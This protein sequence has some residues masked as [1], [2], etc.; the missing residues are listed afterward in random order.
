MDGKLIKMFKEHIG[1]GIWRCLFDPSS[2]L[3]VT[4]GFDSAIKVHH[5]CNSIFHDKGE[6]KLVSDGLNYDSEI[7]VVSSP[8]VLGRC[9][10]L[11]S[12]SEYVRCLHFAEENVLYVATNNG[13]LHHAELSNIED[14]RWTE[15]IQVTEK[16]P[17][18]C[19]DVMPM[20]SNLSLD[21]E[22]VI[23]LGDGRGNVTIVR[24]ASGSIE[25]KMNLS[26]TWPAEKDR[27]LLG[28]YW[29]KSLEFTFSQ[30]ILGV[31]LSYGT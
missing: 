14:V 2:L 6:D 30:L 11:D 19:M 31:C 12:K 3:L 24:L 23:A 13:Y 8:S 21:R 27:Q 5:L 20:Y 18:I 7:F 9:G 28:V 4:A 17:I 1:R 22:D 10:P 29:C 16:A 26:F 15:I 25:P